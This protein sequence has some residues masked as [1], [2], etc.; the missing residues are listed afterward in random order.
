MSNNFLI[1]IVLLLMLTPGCASRQIIETPPESV[2]QKQ[3]TEI[4]AE[5]ELQPVAILEEIER[6]EA[7]VPVNTNLSFQRKAHLRLALL[8]LDRKNTKPNYITALKELEIY[9]KIDS[10]GGKRPEIQ[11]LLTALREVG[12]LTEESKKIKAK[13][14]Q[15]LKENTEIKKTVEELKTLDLKIEERRRQ[16][17]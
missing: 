11:S 15:L 7:M 13:T 14:E 6:L 4:Q 9:I 2:Q 12:R 3:L 16:A 10:E 1:K 8:Y 17:K 5:Q